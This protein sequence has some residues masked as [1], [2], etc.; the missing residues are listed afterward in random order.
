MPQCL[1]STGVPLDSVISAGP[2]MVPPP[3]GWYLQNRPFK[4]ACLN[5]L[6]VLFLVQSVRVELSCKRRP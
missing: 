4:Q 2:G 5:C 3:T 1:F 6:G